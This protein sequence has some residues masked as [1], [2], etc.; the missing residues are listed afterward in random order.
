MVITEAVFCQF[1][2]FFF[3][4]ASMD[5]WLGCLAADPEVAG[6]MPA[7]AFTFR[8]MLNGRG[9][10]TARGQC[11]LRT[12]D[13]QNFLSL[14]LRR[15]SYRGFGTLNPRYYL[16]L[17]DCLFDN[18]STCDRCLKAKCTL[19][20]TETFQI[21]KSHGASFREIHGRIHYHSFRTSPHR[22]YM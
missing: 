14:P 2:R 9:P 1:H 20:Q 11:T 4:S 6:S 17:L 12:L 3:Q 21:C 13:G 10:C 22:K 5:Q 19:L 18:L 8:W 16:S 7:G 15:L